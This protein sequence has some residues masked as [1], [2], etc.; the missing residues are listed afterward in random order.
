MSDDTYRT[1][2]DDLDK[3]IATLEEVL[4]DLTTRLEP[5]LKPVQQA[6]SI[7]D[8]SIHSSKIEANAIT[9]NRIEVREPDS[10]MTAAQ[11]HR[12]GRLR[13]LQNQV[14]TLMGR[15]DL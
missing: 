1:V 13:H 2:C 5:V 10:P 12:L 4:A 9:A 15:I 11:K 3:Q 6:F 8:G 14:Y 7:A